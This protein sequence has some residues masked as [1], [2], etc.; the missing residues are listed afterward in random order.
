MSAMTLAM[1]LALGA[2]PAMAAPR[3]DEAGAAEHR[4]RELAMNLAA[5]RLCSGL[6][7]SERQRDDVLAES[8]VTFLQPEARRALE[9]GEL[10]FDVD[11]ARELVT[12]RRGEL[13]ARARRFGDQ[14]CVILRRDSR[15]PLFTPV[16]VR[17]ELPPADETPWP[18]GDAPAEAAAD[19]T[20]P[21][22]DQGRLERALDVAFSEPADH[23]AAFIA[24]HR[25]R[26]VA[27]RDGAGVGPETQ[28]ESWSM[29]KSVT[30]TLIGILIR[31]GHL[32]LEQPAPV[33]A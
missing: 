10:T 14:G 18:M 8:V 17:A 25:G 12:A 4:G 27:E 9:T 28:L 6:F 20:A 33:P 2:G 31:Q 7:V 21:K 29:G 23:T 3:T 19:V 11:R 16:A 5:K 26:I 24:V 30:A 15:K 13:Q 22:V 1:L 32:S